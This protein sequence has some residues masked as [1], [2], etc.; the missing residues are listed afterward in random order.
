MARRGGPEE[1]FLTGGSRQR[2]FTVT[3]PQMFTAGLKGPGPSGVSAEAS[4]GGWVEPGGP[5]FFMF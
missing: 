4:V 1:R 3:P 5:G 2:G